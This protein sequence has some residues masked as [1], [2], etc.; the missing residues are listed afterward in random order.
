MFELAAATSSDPGFIA[1]SWQILQTYWPM[2]LRGAGVTLLIAITG[3]LT[4]SVI[5]LIIGMIRT[6]PVN[7]TDSKLKKGLFKVINWVLSVYIEI[8]RGTPMI[9]QAM[10]IFYGLA[11]ATG[12]SMPVLLAGFVIVSINTGAYMAEIVRGG[13]IAVDKGQFEAAH[14]IGMNHWQTMV[15]IVMPQVLRNILPATGNEFVI[16]IKDTSVLSVISVT[17]L[18]FASRSIAG[19]NFKYFQVFLITCIMYLIMT[20]TI[21][22]LLRLLERKLAGSAT[23]TIHGSQTTPESEIKV[24]DTHGR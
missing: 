9:V 22:L 18:F 14:S 2:F 13:I 10:V 16:N 7:P 6:I 12:K 17:E 24:E 1:Q 4:G 8:F 23:Y 3:T 11:F 15:N 20:F 21:T 5:G 19:I